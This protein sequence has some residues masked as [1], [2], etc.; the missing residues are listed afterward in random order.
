M[1]SKDLPLTLCPSWGGWGLATLLHRGFCLEDP[2]P[3]VCLHPGRTNGPCAGRGSHFKKL[4]L[5]APLPGT[6]T[7]PKVI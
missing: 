7:I 1:Q 3:P 6:V 4:K 2:G 5:H